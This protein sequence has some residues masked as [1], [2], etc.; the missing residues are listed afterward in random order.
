[1]QPGFFDHQERLDLLERLGDPLP[2][3]ERCVD[4]EAFRSALEK[5]VQAG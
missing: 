5:S 1:M 2:K 3:L 4:W